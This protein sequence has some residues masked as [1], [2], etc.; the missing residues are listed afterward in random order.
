[1]EPRRVTTLFD[2][3]SGPL[4]VGTRITTPF[5]Y[6]PGYPGNA[7]HIHYGIDMGVVTGTP[8]TYPTHL[9]NGL[10]IIAGPLGGYGVCLVVRYEEA[11]VRWYLLWGHL[12][13]ISVASGDHVLGGEV[14]A[15]TDNSGFSFG[16]HLHFGVGRESFYGGSWVDPIPW[17]KAREAPPDPWEVFMATLTQ[18]QKDCLTALATK[19][20]VEFVTEWGKDFQGF[21]SPTGFAARD[22]SF[23]SAHDT[24]APQGP[25]AV[26]INGL[27]ELF[28]ALQLRKEQIDALPEPKYTTLKKWLV[29]LRELAQEP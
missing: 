12:L 24:G 8:T 27:R 22:A 13:R 14:V 11:G 29:D 6:V 3:I 15:E 21:L 4:P 17:L 28:Q 23:D 25:I 16:A 7:D 5:G 19:Q 26:G 9:D 2:G 1:M 18:E 10:V 20:A